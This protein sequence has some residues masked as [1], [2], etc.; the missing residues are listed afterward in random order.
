MSRRRRHRNLLTPWLLLPGGLILLPFLLSDAAGATADLVLVMPLLHVIGITLI[1]NRWG[2][3]KGWWRIALAIAA[4]LTAA[5]VPVLFWFGLWR[6]ALLLAAGVTLRMTI[7]VSGL[8]CGGVILLLCETIRRGKLRWRTWV[9]GLLRIGFAVLLTVPVLEFTALLIER[10]KFQPLPMPGT[11][12]AA[13]E[14]EIRIA[15]VGGSTM[16]GFPYEPHY[17]I[18]HVLAWQLRQM[19]PEHE[20]QLENLAVTGANLEQALARL[21]DLKQRPDVIL[22]YAGHNQFFHRLEELSLARA[23]SWGIIDDWMSLSAVFRIVNPL[24]AQQMMV[25]ETPDGNG[26]LCGR[27]ICPEHLLK[28]RLKR[29]ARQLEDFSRWASQN[30]IAVVFC[31]PVAGESDFEPNLSLGDPGDLETMAAIEE[32]WSQVRSLQQNKEWTGALDLCSRLIQEYPDVAEFQFRAGECCLQLDKAEAARSHFENAINMDQFPIRALDSY[33]EAGL[34]AARQNGVTCVDTEDVIR[35]HSEHGLLGAQSFLDGVHP[36]LRSTYLIG[37]A[38]TDAAM[39]AGAFHRHGT[40]NSPHR[41]TFAESMQDHSIESNVL[42]EAY[43][44]TVDVLNRY[45]DFR[46]FDRERRLNKA[47]EYAALAAKLRDQNIVPGEDG[48]ESLDV[49]VQYRGSD[50]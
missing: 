29:Y 44:T 12:A 13:A 32:L 14:G 19:Y 26:H 40:P 22:V 20:V 11:L 42:A 45:S 18:G 50:R 30:D 34:Q 33:R 4:N 27:T 17:S 37:R 49:E 36:N 43:E 38:V 9:P 21:G 31:S 25:T 48:T 15:A 23:A 1:W 10:S 3:P 28:T 16:L 47:A 2:R 39:T 5:A 24:L 8:F 46:P 35:R 41:L 7:A 6:Y